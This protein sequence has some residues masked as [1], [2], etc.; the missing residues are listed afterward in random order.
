MQAYSAMKNMIQR[1]NRVLGMPADT[2]QSAANE[3]FIVLVRV[4]GFPPR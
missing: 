3:F 4:L 1:Y 2:P